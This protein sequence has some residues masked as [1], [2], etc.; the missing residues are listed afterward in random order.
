[1]ARPCAYPL[2][3]PPLQS[4]VI[5]YHNSDSAHG[6][7]RKHCATWPFCSNILLPAHRPPMLG[8]ISTPKETQMPEQLNLFETPQPSWAQELHLRLEPQTRDQVLAILVDMART[9]LQARVADAQAGDNDE[10]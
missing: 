7:R 8:Y 3:G 2:S 5:R 4:A 10:Q 6:P 9:A 1:M